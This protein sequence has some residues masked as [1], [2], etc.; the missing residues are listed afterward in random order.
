MFLLFFAHSSSIVIEPYCADKYFKPNIIGN[1][2][3]QFVSGVPGINHHEETPISITEKP[4]V[5]V[6]LK[7]DEIAKYLV[8]NGYANQEKANTIQKRMKVTNKIS[9]VFNDF[10]CQDMSTDFY[11]LP[12]NQ[13]NLNNFWNKII[14]RDAV[15]VKGTKSGDNV[16]LK[17]KRVS[18]T[19]KKRW[20][21]V[22]ASTNWKS[23]WCQVKVQDCGFKPTEKTV[24]EDV[25]KK[26]YQ[27]KPQQVSRYQCSM[28]PTQEYKCTN[29]P[30]TSYQCTGF[31][32]SQSCGF[33]TTYQQK[34]GYQTVT[35]QQC[36]YKTVTEQKCD[37]YP[38]TK[39]EWVKKTVSEYRCDDKLENKFFNDPY[40]L[41][42]IVFTDSWNKTE[43][44][45]MFASV[46]EKI[47]P[48]ISI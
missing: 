24:Y 29:Q 40:Q 13:K 47:Q 36:G 18:G 43:V 1:P 27:C 31:G 19:M 10:G 41:Y 8:D 39:K 32:I 25:T 14:T 28:V 3:T 15:A 20:S 9:T 34:C 30:V 21:K 35:K 4:V 38:V 12:D 45:D 42:K 48:L 2:Y 23:Y 33:K 22:A 26:E 11:K 46:Q 7:Q 37:F 5:T 17:L 16:T 44:E 6:T